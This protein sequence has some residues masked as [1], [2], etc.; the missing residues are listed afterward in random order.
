VHC[1]AALDMAANCVKAAPYKVPAP[2]K[3]RSFCF[4]GYGLWFDFFVGFF[5]ACKFHLSSAIWVFQFS[6]LPH[7]APEIY[8]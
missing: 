5:C 4:V 2:N 7:N 1:P 8:F 6:F 3:A